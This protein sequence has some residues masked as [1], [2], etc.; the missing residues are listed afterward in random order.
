MGPEIMVIVIVAI[1][2]GTIV[3]L[4]RLQI[5]KE[6]GIPPG[7]NEP[8]YKHFK[9]SGANV[10]TKVLEE[11]NKRLENLETIVVGGELDSLPSHATEM[12]LRDQI[13]RLSK[14]IEELE[15]ERKSV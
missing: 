4:R 13:A 7:K 12:E 14:R 15:N 2:S 11:M 3:K 10:N 8:H 5:E 6:Q 9:R 1:V